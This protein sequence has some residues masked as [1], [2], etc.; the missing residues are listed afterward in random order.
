MYMHKC[1]F[2]PIKMR[3]LCEE[4]KKYKM[5]KLT[6]DEWQRIVKSGIL[7][8][9]CSECGVF[10]DL[11]G[12]GAFYICKST[13]SNFSVPNWMASDWIHFIWLI[14][15]DRSTSCIKLLLALC[16]LIWT[17]RWQ[18]NSYTCRD[19]ISYA[20]PGRKRGKN[21]VKVNSD[22]YV[23]RVHGRITGI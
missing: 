19:G 6:R 20:K 4:Y 16:P 23:V 3:K 17:D 9:E 22:L 13:P 2:N 5:L 18:F 8:G 10:I 21:A 11:I 1:E 7:W 14:H 15:F 12:P